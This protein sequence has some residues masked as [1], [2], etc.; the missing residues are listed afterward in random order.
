M[1]RE[2]AIKHLTAKLECLMRSKGVREKCDSYNSYEGCYECDL[3]Y[4]QGNIGEQIE[5]LKLAIKALKQEPCEDAISRKSVLD[6]LV[7]YMDAFYNEN[8]RMMYSDHIITNADCNDL[9]EWIRSFPSVNPQAKTGHWNAYEV[10]QGGIK[11][12]WLE[13]SE[14]KWSNA[15]VIPRKYCPNCGARMMEKEDDKE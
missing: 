15:L 14:C 12:E 9:K 5:S 11:E 7:E 10:F 4:K 13:C 6:S 1:T 2:E 3:G 8:G